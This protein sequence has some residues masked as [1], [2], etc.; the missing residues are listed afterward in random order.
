[1]DLVLGLSLTSST[2]R[3]VLVEGVTGEGA[4]VDRGAFDFDAAIDPDELLDVLLADV[5]DPIHAIGVTWTN[6]AEQTVSGVLGALTT[7]GYGNAI[8]ISELEA[9]EVLAEG[10]AEIADYDDV[11]VC[12]VEPDAAV[13]A[14]VGAGGVT[15]D[16]IP[17]P[18][19]GADVIELPSSVI[20]ML[21]LNEWRPDAIF[22]VGSAGDLQ[23]VQSTLDDVTTSP[24][25]SAADA[26]LALARGAALASARAVNTL[27]ARG[28]RRPS[29]VGALAS[30]LVAAVVTFVVSISAA[31]GLGLTGGDHR[32]QAANAAEQSTAG[33][34]APP[35]QIVQ[36]ATTPAEARPVV[37]QTIARAAPP[38]PAYS[39]PAPAAEISEPPAYV[40]P[41]PEPAYSPPAPVYSPPAPA[42]SPPAPAYVPPAPAPAYTPP[43][44]NYVPPVAPQ[45]RL[46]DRIIERIPIINRFHEPDYSYPR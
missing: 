13:V 17:R 34:S 5:V 10:I 40:P 21:E 33:E 31:V 7:R 43:V 19:D 1:M 41:A 12:I 8:A 16:R 38:P 22:V 11:A 36:K 42:Y 18:L 46:R 2:V 25:F 28:P 4:T 37:A 24:V 44:Q 3:W 26:E 45:P 14:M 20:T 35:A 27:D 15:V 6:E 9:A 39:P 29:R 32:P 23:L 30:V